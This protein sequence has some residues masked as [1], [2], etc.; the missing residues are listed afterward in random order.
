MTS[1]PLLRLESH[2]V[3]LI[4]EANVILMRSEVRRRSSTN[5]ETADAVDN[6]FV[7]DRDVDA[8]DLAQLLAN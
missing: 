6:S 4:T 3:S 7:G 8:A 5:D 2:V 1:S